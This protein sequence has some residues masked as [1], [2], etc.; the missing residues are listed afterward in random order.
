[1]FGDIAL[2]NQLKEWRLDWEKYGDQELIKKYLEIMKEIDNI[3]RYV[4]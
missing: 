4:R 2:K 3:K 1:M